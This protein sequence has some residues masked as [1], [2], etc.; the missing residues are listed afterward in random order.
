[1]PGPRGDSLNR[2]LVLLSTGT[3]TIR[4]KRETMKMRANRQLGGVWLRLESSRS[5]ST[6]QNFRRTADVDTRRRTYVR[7]IVYTIA[8]IRR[9]HEGL[10]ISVCEVQQLGQ[11]LYLADRSHDFNPIDQPKVNIVNYRSLLTRTSRKKI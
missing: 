8:Y 9:R 1:M 10:T 11:H 6:R 7:T 5:K 3:D 2:S 4:S